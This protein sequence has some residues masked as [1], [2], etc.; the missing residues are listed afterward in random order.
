MNPFAIYDTPVG[1][2]RIEEEDGAIIS[3]DNHPGP[4]DRLNATD[5]LEEAGRQLA[6]YFA[7]N[8]HEFTIPYRMKG[9]LFQE[10]VWKALSQIP[11]GQTK[12]Y[13]EIAEIVGN[14]K[15]YRAVGMANNKNKLAIVI[16][17][18]RV[19]G[20]SG[21]LVGYAGGEAIKEYLLRLESSHQ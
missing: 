16:P 7:G 1:H 3:I 11:Y 20:T 10:K 9:T 15:G 5:L 2:Y 13:K 12:T 8:R 4:V 18:H 21:K 6:E 17:C 14:P 19:I